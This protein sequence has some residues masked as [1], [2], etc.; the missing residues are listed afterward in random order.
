MAALMA[1]MIVHVAGSYGMIPGIPEFASTSSVQAVGEDVK[2]IQAAL[3]A[4]DI[5]DTK[6]SQCKAIQEK[7]GMRFWAE[8]LNSLT[9]RYSEIT[10]QHFDVP[11]CAELGAV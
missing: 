1:M 7:S 6:M 8:R 5:L 3:L 2:Q 10:G 4:K 11:S 9:N